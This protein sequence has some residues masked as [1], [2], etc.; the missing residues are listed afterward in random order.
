MLKPGG[1]LLFIEH[2]RAGD[3]G[4]ACWQDRLERPW[5]FLADGCHCNRDTVATLTDA[6]FEPGAVERGELPKAPPLVRPLVR[7]R[8][9][10]AS[11]RS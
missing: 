7:G 10:L 8:A 1:E 2:V 11:Y 6:G 3:P 5:R 4:L 9:A